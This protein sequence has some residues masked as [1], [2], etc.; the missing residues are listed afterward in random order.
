[1]SGIAKA[2]PKL[3]GNGMELEEIGDGRRGHRAKDTLG[4][5]MRTL[6]R[7]LAYVWAAPNTVLGLALGALSFQR[8]RT[9]AGVLVFDARDRGFVWVLARRGWRAITFGHIVLS[10][11]PVEG[12]TLFHELAHVRQYER[13]GPLF[14]PCYV[15]LHLFTGYRQNPFETQ[16]TR[17]ELR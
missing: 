8:P 13:L 15:A 12:V 14:L 10:S 5:V 1:M 4:P 16:A 2:H 7:F 9:A 6:L 3:D 17:A 11:K